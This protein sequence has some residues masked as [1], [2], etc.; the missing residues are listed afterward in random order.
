MKDQD[1]KKH[2]KTPIEQL[3]E[4]PAKDEFLI[5][6]L[7]ASAGGIQALQE[8]FR[9]VPENSG[10][11]YVVILHLSPDHD[12]QLA[13]VLQRETKIPVTQVTER[14]NIQPDHIYVVPPNQH[15]T[16]EDGFIAVS[17]NTLIE[18]RRA[19]VDIFFRTLADQHGPRAIAVILSGTGA[20]GSMGLKR[21]KERGGA[22]FAQNPREAEFSEMP[23]NAIATEMVDD[24]LP[25]ADI[26]AKI[27]SYKTSLGKIQITGDADKRPED[28]QQALREIF[29]QIRL[30]T[31]HDFS[32]Y[33]RLTVLRRIERRI[34]VRN[35]PHLP[36]YAKYLTENPEEVNA[37]QKDLLISVTNFFRDKKP[38]DLM[39]QEI[40]P[41][42]FKGKKNE[43]QVRIW[44]AGCATGEEAYS[45]AMLCAEKTMG[46]ID[47]PTVQIFATDI[48]ESAVAQAR[49]GLYSLNDAADVSP[50]RLRRF[51]NKEGDFFRIRREIR[52]MIMFAHH[53]FLKDPPFS[54]LD[55]VSC[56][57]VM[58]Y[59]NQVAQERVIE[60]FH[61][62][63]NPAGYLFLGTSESVDGASDLY[64]VYNRENHVFQSRQVGRRSYPV[65]ESTPSLYFEK[66]KKDYASPETENKILERISFG[67]LH[68]QLLEEYAPPSLVVNEEH[69]ILHLTE[70]AGK[71][72]QIGGGELSQNLLKLVKPELRLE[73]RSALYQAMQRQSAVE[74][75]GLKVNIDDVAE[76][77]NIHVRPV[78]RTGDAAKGFILVVFEPTADGGGHEIL[79]SADEPMA[80]HLEEELIRIKAQLRAANEQHDFQAEEMKASNEELQA[81][82]EELRSAAEELETSKEELQSINEELRT[83]NQELKVKI[84]ET[85][86]VSNNLQN[87]I[88]ST[89]IGTIFLDRSFRVALFTPAARNIFNLIPA[90][91]GRPLTD[92][93]HKLEHDGLSHDAETVL[94]KL[95]TIEKEVR[96]KDGRDFL[97]RLTP[98]RTDEDRI[99]GVV[100]TFLDITERKKANE[101]MRISEEKYRTLFESIDEGF[102]LIDLILDK[103]GKPVDTYHIEANPAYERHTGLHDIVGKRGLEVMPAIGEWLNFYGDVARTGKPMRLEYFVEPIKRWLTCYVFRIGGEGSVRLAVV[104]NDITE[105]KRIEAEK[106]FIQKLSDSLRSA[107]N[108]VAL[109][110]IVT[111]MTMD[112][113]A[114]D[115][116]FYCN[117]NENIVTIKQ[118]ALRG[119][120]PSV[121]GTYPLNSFA[122]FK[123]AIDDGLPLIVTDSY[124]T[125]ILDEGLREIVIGLQNISFIVIPV[126]KNNQAIS[127]FCLVQSTPRNWTD[128]EVRLAEE[129]AERTW[130]AVE[131][132]KVEEA[133]RESEMIR[134][135]ALS[136]GR[137]G[138]WQWNLHKDMATGDPGFMSLFRLPPTEEMLPAET[139]LSV[140][141]RT[142]A[143]KLVKLF[144]KKFKPGEEFD[145]L[146][147]IG[148]ERKTPTWINIRGQAGWD[149][150]MLLTG[151]AFDVSEQKNAADAL[152]KS[153]L[154]FKTVSDAVPQLIW[155]NDEQS[156]FTYFNSRWT[157]YSG[158]SP[159]SSVQSGWQ[160]IVHPVDIK[161]ADDLWTVSKEK[162]AVFNTEM[163]LRRFDDI[164]RWHIIRIVPLKDEQDNVLSWFG[165]A[166]DIEE[167]KEAEELLRQSEARLRT[168]M[169]SAADF[170]VITID[171]SGF[172]QAW[173]SGAE[174][175]FGYT[176]K[177][178]TGK[179]IDIIFTPE[180]RAAKIHLQEMDVARDQ[181]KAIGERW[182]IKKD[183][184]FFFM[185]GVLAPIYDGELSGYVKIGRDMTERQ[186]Q[187]E[188]LHISEE[189]NRIALD[190]AEM[191]A[192]DWNITIDVLE[193]SEQHYIMLGTTPSSITKTTD[194]FLKFI[195]PDDK[196][197]VK[198][199][200]TRAAEETGNYQEEFRI[201]REDTGET[202][203]MSGY[204]KVIGYEEGKATRMVGV[205]SD[206]TKR[207]LLEQ[208][209]DEFIGIASHELKTP[210][211]SIKGYAEILQEMFTDIDPVSAGLM[212]KMD[213]QIDRLTVLI[214][215]L[216]DTTKISEGQLVLNP[217]EF[218]LNQLLEEQVKDLEY[219]SQNHQLILKTG[220]VKPI[221]AD[222]ERIGQVITNLITNAVK[223]SPR[224]GKVLIT[225][226]D[227][228]DG[229]KVSVQDSGIGISKSQQGRV[230]DR[231]F[232]VNNPEMQTYP[233]MGL[234]LYITAGIIKRHGGTI[235]VTSK[236]GKGSI[237]YFVLPYPQEK[238]RSEEKDNYSG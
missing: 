1:S 145:L 152:Q 177:E 233:G 184:S 121:S 68:Q 53:N 205:M 183:G 114:A 32:N 55:L 194:Y 208:Q 202:R 8:F 77:V 155:A 198:N 122:L 126:K 197:R 81:M 63:L 175:I 159:E 176:E 85:S 206:I 33:K 75:R 103:N 95:T 51:F 20:N 153:E 161:R 21:I 147:K 26:P 211:T 226:E 218:D 36:A 144:S 44:V 2:K 48:D 37:L 89:D 65:P 116:C 14:V 219:L 56:R 207:K 118:D 204:G 47:M 109:E 224:G 148:K 86:L 178:V 150:P 230:F 223:Y 203:W 132:A 213:A 22:C 113:F 107:S 217:E 182:H 188:L 173:S 31:G 10:I 192:W 16:I 146:V 164:Y 66:F 236:S 167:I 25:V 139:F 19:P 160:A 225:S 234:G 110:E 60:T 62:A 42:L 11:A 221:V 193:W 73:L 195:F 104:F 154:R 222:K 128:A 212:Q 92:I 119:G 70:R 34:N 179:C 49:E 137:M 79:L 162:A 209:K 149:D 124:T 59:L 58:I 67:D 39:D 232:R 38:F 97:M 87:L 13:A 29:T 200:L 30:K 24:I 3:Q 169:D 185:S 129:I 138:A 45:L 190:S 181:G 166:T 171:T 156:A 74:A 105:R 17:D 127:L 131:R 23:R 50:E 100:I 235:S 82:N 196:A 228:G 134:R 54:H 72:L 168:T 115:R 165:S 123:K 117:V 101:A 238:A 141:S 187:D 84:E 214:R 125:P 120:L 28:Q 140:L 170:A 191:G 130:A 98:Y 5:V 180:D 231:F 64:A 136:G 201:I 229:I 210:I 91:Y 143:V 220:Q 172:I 12:S 76:T 61:F 99:K 57:N 90:D 88:N 71:Y 112:Y 163:R 133:L 4:K 227:A 93:T 78:L 94:E 35:L 215:T 157:E 6:G 189:R 199:S 111:Q 174:K 83:V 27:I 18:E 102:A 52:E 108:P 186:A 80:R 69:D 106:E 46:A 96:T 43:D 7:G 142:D 41:L 135:M 151:V 216:L 158:L 9:H 15:L 40:L 237:F